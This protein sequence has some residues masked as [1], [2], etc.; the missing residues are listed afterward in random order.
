MPGLEGDADL[1]VGLEPGDA[2]AVPGAW[3]NDYKRTPP[4]INLNAPRRNDARKGIV[5]GLFERPAID[6]DLGR[7][8]KHVRGDLG[9]MLVVLVA[10]LP[11]HIPEQDAPLRGVDHV[12]D[13]RR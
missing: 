12:L 3:I 5:D 10:A 7:I 9:H 6:H 8:A 1:A 4:R 11:H 2:R 13:G